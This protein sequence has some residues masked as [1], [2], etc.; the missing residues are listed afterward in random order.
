MDAAA[1]VCVLLMARRYCKCGGDLEKAKSDGFT[2]VER[3]QADPFALH[4]S[5][6][7]ELIGLEVAA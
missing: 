3:Q 7:F 1:G 5:I 4:Q 6:E 2:I